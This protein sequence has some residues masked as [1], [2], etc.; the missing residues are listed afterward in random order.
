MNHSPSALS[1]AIAGRLLR[2]LLASAGLLVFSFGAYLQ[3]QAA[4]GMSPWLS[5]NQ[6]L[7]LHLPI[8]YGQASIL[9]SLLFVAADLLLREPIGLGTVL[10]A[11]VVG[12][13]SDLFL[14]L[15]W[16]PVMTEFPAQLAVL[17]VGMVIVCF[18]QYLYMLAGLSC[19]PRDAF[20]VAV[21]KRFPRLSI[22]T[23]NLMILA[24]AQLLAYLLG[25]PIGLGTLITVFGSG[26]VMDAVFRLLR[27]EPRN[28]KHENLLETFKALRAAYQVDHVLG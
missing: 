1:R 9:C 8:T 26:V 2:S 16:V 27:F 12:W 13:G 15:G 19:G 4:I 23:I 21:G 6:S 22:G 7:T 17:L 5:L 10:D 20:L 25:G 3:L 24:I 18:G 11:L 28:V 14:S